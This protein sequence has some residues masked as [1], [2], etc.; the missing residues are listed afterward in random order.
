MKLAIFDFDGTLFTKE[1]LPYT[2]KFWGKAGYSRKK[3]MVTF[4]KIIGLLIIYKLKLIRGMDKERFRGLASQIFLEMFKGLN[5][6]ELRDFFSRCSVEMEKDFNQEVVSLLKRA[7]DDGYHTVLLSGA[8]EMLLQQLATELPIDSVIGTEI[9][10]TDQGYIDFDKKIEVVSGINKMKMIE[11]IFNDE[12]VNW[13]ESK[14]YADSY[15][16][17]DILSMVGHPY[18]VNPD[19]RLKEIAIKEDWGIL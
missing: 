10:F 11:K 9:Y 12:K 6:E 8:Y 4:A 19:S 1:T 7:K 13:S 14:A 5:E 18:A 16:D 15:Y 17:F 2:L 3:Q